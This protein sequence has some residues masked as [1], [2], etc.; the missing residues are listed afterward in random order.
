MNFSEN[1]KNLS[2]IVLVIG[3]FFGI[4]VTAFFYFIYDFGAV[5]LLVGGFAGGKFILIGLLIVF[6]ATAFTKE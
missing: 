4:I 6:I 1:F 3:L 2:K 5:S